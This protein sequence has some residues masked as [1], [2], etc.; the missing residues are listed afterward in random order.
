MKT[1]DVIPHAVIG[2]LITIALLVILEGYSLIASNQSLQQTDSGTLLILLVMA[3]FA[4][5]AGGFVSAFLSAKK[6]K[7][8]LDKA[9]ITSTASAILT[10]LFV[11]IITIGSMVLGEGGDILTFTALL[12]MLGAM[13]IST[14]A[15]GGVLFAFINGFGKSVI[16]ESIK[17][18]WKAYRKNPPALIPPIMFASLSTLI[19]LYGEPLI[20]T[21]GLGEIELIILSLVIAVVSVCLTAFTI[22]S[23]ALNVKKKTGLKKLFEQSIKKGVHAFKSLIVITLPVL[24]LIVVVLG[25]ATLSPDVAGI[26]LMV[27][28]LLVLIGLVYLLLFSFAPIIAVLEKVT[29][30]QSMKKSYA[31][32]KKRVMLVI[33]LSAMLL[34]ITVFIDV[35]FMG[36]D[37]VAFT[38]GNDTSL[39]TSF[40]SQIVNM[41]IVTAGL[42][43]FYLEE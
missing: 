29:P 38:V 17:K 19:A 8:T 42:A 21:L 27:M 9:L 15:L 41:I 2:S 4:F 26:V 5:V 7:N 37:F 13:A 40:V 35:G 3:V 23:I 32:V 36:L 14:S 30:I 1:K 28:P 34:L 22:T 12:T 31:F 11:G 10:V 24:A 18:M 6:A 25:A 20:E 39:V 33:G 43:A 16:A